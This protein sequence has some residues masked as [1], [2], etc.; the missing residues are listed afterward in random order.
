MRALCSLLLLLVA[1]RAV[2]PLKLKANFSEF[3]VDNRADEDNVSPGIAWTG[4]PKKADSFVLILESSR[5]GQ[6][7]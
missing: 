1:E 4:V 3:P 6:E 5:G 2:A 7:V